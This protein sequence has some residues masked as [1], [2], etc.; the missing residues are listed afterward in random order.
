M[1]PF[2]ADTLI[3]NTTIGQRLQQLG[4]KPDEVRKFQSDHQ[5]KPDGIVGPLTWHRLFASRFEVVPSSPVLR[6]RAIE[7]ARTQLF[8]REKTGHNDG[9]EVEEYL[10]CVGLGKGYSWCQAFVYWCYRKA[11]E[12]LN[13]PNPVTHTAGVLFHWQHTNGHKL[14]PIKAIAGDIFIMDFGNGEGH[15]G[16]I[17]EVR[18]DTITTVEGNTNN[19]GSRNGNGVYERSRKLSS[20]KG[21]IRY[22]AS[23]GLV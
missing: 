12:A 3:D 19:D 17:S 8:V 7:I 10:Q 2:P 18:Y 6:Y 1:P 20:L 16:L 15:T 13:T 21:V 9:K 23:T 5:L 22:G 11:A 4:Y 14:Q